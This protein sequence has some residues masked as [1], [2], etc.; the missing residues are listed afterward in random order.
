MAASR[1]VGAAILDGRG[2]VLAAQRD[3]P[4]DLAGR[5]EFPGGKLRPGEAELD[6]LVRECAEELGVVVAP[7]EFVGEVPIP[8]HRWLRVWTARLVYGDLTATEHRE[9]RWVAAGELDELDWLVP[10]RPLLEPLKLLL[11]RS[12][13]YSWDE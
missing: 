5:W 10:D 11:T 4:A 3:G 2:R 6:G 12:V 9:L 7:Q 8:G 1:V 13:A